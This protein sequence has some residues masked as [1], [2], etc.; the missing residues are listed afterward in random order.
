[1][2]VYKQFAKH[3]P[4]YDKQKFARFN[5]IL[6]NF[7]MDEKSATNYVRGVVFEEYIYHLINDNLDVDDIMCG[8]TVEFDDGHVNEF[9]ILLMKNNHLHAI[10]CKFANNI[11]AENT[12]YKLDSTTHYL[13][14][15]TKAMLL[16][17]SENDIKFSNGVISRA[18]SADIKIY[19]SKNFNKKHFLIDIKEWF[20]LEYKGMN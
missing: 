17:V 4:I 20:E 14:E 1:L 16:V 15:E 11:N 7:E 8:V 19:Y 12:I 5:S 6:Q 10:E 2:K 18:K 9:D 13:D 3:F